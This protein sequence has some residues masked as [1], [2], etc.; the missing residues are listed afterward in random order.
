[1][2]SEKSRA[3]TSAEATAQTSDLKKESYPDSDSES[4][5]KLWI[6]ELLLALQAP[7]S[8]K[9]QKIYWQLFESGLR[10]HVEH[11]FCVGLL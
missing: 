4:R 11:K 10:Q 3:E 2:R 6:G 5:P 8:Q 1:M 7:L 9:Q